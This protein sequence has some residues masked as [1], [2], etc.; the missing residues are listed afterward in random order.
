MSETNP[1]VLPVGFIV[2]F[3]EGILV[4]L[5]VGFVLS[6]LVGCTGVKGEIVMCKQAKSTQSGD[7]V[8][9]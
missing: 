9:F 8:P 4:Y 6:F 2:G 3:T 7:T 5:T 1:L